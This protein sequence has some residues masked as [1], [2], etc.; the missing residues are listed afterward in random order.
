MNKQD[1]HKQIVIDYFF[2]LES[3]QNRNGVFEQFFHGD[4]IQLGSFGNKIG[5]NEVKAYYDFREELFSFAGLTFS[6]LQ[7]YDNF[8]DFDL[9]FYDFH[10]RELSAETK[11]IALSADTSPFVKL[12][13]STPPTGKKTEIHLQGTF[14]FH[15]DKVSFFNLN[16][17]T[18]NFVCQLFPGIDVPAPP[19]SEITAED[20][21][22][23]IQKSFPVSLN[24]SEIASIAFALGGFTPDQSAIYLPHSPQTIEKHLASGYQKLKCSN[25]YECLEKIQSAGKICLFTT[26][27]QYQIAYS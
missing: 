1:Q 7:S 25:T 27:C 16:G 18:D 23:F 24:S 8:V 2:Q 12:L 10:D 6:H 20:L 14:A 11:N 19:P 26:L 3:K 22:I 21:I 15:Q 4:V 17:N 5:I 13:A 9:H